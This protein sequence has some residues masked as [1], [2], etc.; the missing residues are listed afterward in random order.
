MITKLDIMLDPETFDGEYTGTVEKVVVTDSAAQ[1]TVNF[2]F[3]GK[4]ERVL[5][6]ISF[7]RG[8]NRTTAMLRENGI[9]RIDDLKDIKQLA[10]NISRG[11][12]NITSLGPGV[13]TASVTG[14]TSHFIK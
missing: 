3:N 9:K 2:D 11:W 13:K 7:S 12:I 14:D 1:F 4:P 10:F 8:L 5:A 6:E